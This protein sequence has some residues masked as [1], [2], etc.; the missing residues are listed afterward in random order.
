MFTHP[1]CVA[2]HAECTAPVK[3]T[4]GS[5]GFDLTSVE[6]VTIL[7]GER[8]MVST[9]LSITCPPGCYG[10]IAP[11]SGLALK[12][13]IDVLAG[14]I[15]PDYTGIVQAILYNTSDTPFTV[16]TGM[17]MCQLIYERY[18]DFPAIKYMAMSLDP[19]LEAHAPSERGSGGFGSTGLRDPGEGRS[20][21][22]P[23]LGH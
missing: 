21:P 4:A 16:E 2:H 8:R 12:H 10:R 14:V 3:G 11:R 20:Y 17:R 19:N 5:A 7:P 6:T 13:G 18:Q 22:D 9:G 15:D 1:Q 23:V